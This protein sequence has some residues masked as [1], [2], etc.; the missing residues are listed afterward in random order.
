MA[1]AWVTT[2]PP[3]GTVVRLLRLSGF[4]ILQQL[5]IEEALLRWGRSDVRL[6]DFII[7]HTTLLSAAGATR[8][9]PTHAG[10]RRTTG[11]S[12]TTAPPSPPL[13]WE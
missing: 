5:K 13:C 2:R 4:P 10:Q 8:A 1:A 3:P 9:L 7:P 6:E 12:S 11:L